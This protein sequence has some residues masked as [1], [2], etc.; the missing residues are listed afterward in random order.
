[1]L[2]N[3][4]LTEIRTFI[5]ECVYILYLAFFK[6]FTFSQWLRRVHPE[7][8]IDSNP[9]RKRFGMDNNPR[10]L[11][12][13]RQIQFL[14][15]IVPL[16]IILII[17]PIY[18]L[19]ADE[20]RWDHSFAYLLGWWF[21]LWL[22]RKGNTQLER[23]FWF[24]IGFSVFV[25]SILGLM[26]SFLPENSLLEIQS[27]LGIHE[28]LK[29]LI[30]IIWMFILGFALATVV[31]ISVGLPIGVA[32]GVAGSLSHAVGIQPYALFQ[33][34]NW[35]SY[36]AFGAAW[37]GPFGVAFGVT[38]SVG[39]SIVR[40]A[41]LALSR[42]TG[43]GLLSGLAIFLIGNLIRNSLLFEISLW[44][45]AL[46][47]IALGA[48]IGLAIG[49]AINV[50]TA[51][52]THS[53]I[54]RFNWGEGAKSVNV[55]LTSMLLGGLIAIAIGLANNPV[56]GIA[57]FV[58]WVLGTL[59]VYFWLPELFWIGVLLLIT[60]R[61]ST[62]RWLRYLPI[63]FDELIFL[64]LPWISSLIIHT[65]AQKPQTAL[66]TIDYLL[67]F[68]NQRSTAAKLIVI[69]A[70]DALQRCKTPR[71]IEAISNQLAWIPFPPPKEVGSLLP[72]FLAISQEVRAALAGTSNYRKAQALELPCE[73][74]RQ[75][76]AR[77][78]FVSK[79]R[80]AGLFNT[81]AKQWL[82]TLEV[83]RRDLQKQSQEADEIPQEYIAGPSLDPRLAKERFKGRVDLFREIETLARAEQP[84][85]LL[86]SGERRTGKTSTLKYLPEKMSAEFVPIL[87]DLQG[88]SIATTLHKLAESLASE[89]RVSA[90]QSRNFRL[91]PIDT[92]ALEQDP[93][94]ELREWFTRIEATVQGKRFILCL[95]EFERLNEVF[96]T[97]K[98]PFLDFLRYISQNR[99]QWI[100]LFSGSHALEDLP[101]TWS[102]Y[103]IGYRSLRVSYLEEPEARELIV[104]PVEIF[105]N[106]YKPEAVNRIIE[107][108]H[109]QPYLVQLMCFRLV[110]RLN[111]Q[112][113]QQVTVEDV[114]AV[115]PEVLQEGQMYFSE[116]Y[117]Q[118][119]QED[120]G[121]LISLVEDGAVS[122]S[123]T[124]LRKLYRRQILEKTP[125]NIRFQVPLFEEYIRLRLDSYS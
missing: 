89:M 3:I 49:V 122:A 73:Q 92:Y 72:E 70:I 54:R 7:L 58:A 15:A 5:R 110:E 32:I 93:L 44:D 103:L 56:A 41:A 105:P 26:H 83:A 50:S 102:D 22:T 108:T 60:P 80:E 107:L 125:S 115:V 40:R 4:R 13:A 48:V 43:F 121:V 63:Y 23:W 29:S 82:G 18:S 62:E 111:R 116:R 114:E 79:F 17:G 8:V 120:Q 14:S 59:R 64:P 36:A 16:I 87:V 97:P 57:C 84:T 38:A 1:M 96:N 94:P 75:L 47:S 77:L 106:I 11:R 71:D 99:G 123:K 9:L 85:P 91:P 35:T 119:T 117:M 33:V 12:Y 113:R 88:V 118:L 124:T 20:Y 28:R 81:I 61:N 27:D 10:V 76:Q 53:L 30:Y 68:T 100:V 66:D 46:I 104:K 39:G 98:Q 90:Q 78:P 21:S 45:L 86:L 37:G 34:S 67:H 51:T 2:E 95:D 74:L 42:S 109:C 31:G 25:I 69:I 112:Q 19:I 65:Y 52:V 55:Q 101:T 24:F 6:P